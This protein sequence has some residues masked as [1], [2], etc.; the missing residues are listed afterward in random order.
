MNDC[1]INEQLQ[2]TSRSQPVNPLSCSVPK[3]PMYAEIEQANLL[4]QTIDENSRL[5]EKL[6]QIQLAHDNQLEEYDQCISQL[7]NDLNRTQLRVTTLQSALNQELHIKSAENTHLM[8]DDQIDALQNKN[9]GVSREHSKLE[10]LE[11]EKDAL[12]QQLQAFATEREKLISDNAY[13][14]NLVESLQNQLDGTRATSP[15]TKYPVESS[16]PDQSVSCARCLR[17]LV[18]LRDYRNLYGKLV[19]HAAKCNDDASTTNSL[20]EDKGGDCEFNVPDIQCVPPGHKK[21]RKFECNNSACSK[22]SLQTNLQSSTGT[23]RRKTG[24]SDRSTPEKDSPCD[25]SACLHLSEP[26]TE[27]SRAAGVNQTD[28]ICGVPNTRFDELRYNEWD[29][30]QETIATSWEDSVLGTTTRSLKFQKGTTCRES[31]LSKALKQKSVLCRSLYT[32]NAILVSKLAAMQSR[33]RVALRAVKLSRVRSAVSEG[34]KNSL[35]INKKPTKNISHPTPCGVMNHRLVALM[36]QNALLRNQLKHSRLEWERK[37]KQLEVLLQANDVRKQSVFS[38]SPF[39][40]KRRKSLIK[41]TA[42]SLHSGQL[43]QSSSARAKQSEG[44]EFSDS[45]SSPEVHCHSHVGNIVSPARE[46]NECDQPCEN[47]VA[48]MNACLPSPLVLAKQRN[49][50]LVQQLRVARATKIGLKRQTIEL[51]VQLKKALNALHQNKHQLERSERIIQ[52]LMGY[53]HSL[54]SILKQFEEDSTIY[55]NDANS[56][57]TA[58][59][60]PAENCEMIHAKVETVCSKRNPFEFSHTLA[61]RLRNALR[62]KQQ[63]WAEMR[64]RVRTSAQQELRRRALIEELRDNLCQSRERQKQIKAE[65]D[66]KTELVEV[67]RIT[68]DRQRSEIESQRTRLKTLQKEKSRLVHELDSCQEAHNFARSQLAELQR[69]LITLGLTARTDDSHSVND[70]RLA[71]DGVPCERQHVGG[72]MMSPYEKLFP[73]INYRFSGLF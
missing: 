30:P 19:Y 60:S 56:G 34:K 35:N 70:C 46:A 10:K 8:T 50:C 38:K 20:A 51:T 16:D 25:S 68:E 27:Q 49:N 2:A 73:L 47:Q 9:E 62:T 21:T 11:A 59:A 1:Q 13:L 22:Q 23:A 36:K 42:T 39:T 61:V 71:A 63:L 69:R 44:G 18:E 48:S 14:D 31:Q 7:K 24:D 55:Q 5:R 40:V 15:T 52:H 57:L 37:Y 64:E 28:D 26:E 65:L 3:C 33:L 54:D 4:Q 32:Q 53:M 41:Q 66:K 72:V 43:S 12:S 29:G 6:E 67:A 58:Q 45:C 17:L